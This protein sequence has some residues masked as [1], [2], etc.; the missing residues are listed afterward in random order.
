MCCE[1]LTLVE[2][3]GMCGCSQTLG[4]KKETCMQ[5]EN[6]SSLCEFKSA[7]VAVRLVLLRFCSTTATEWVI[8]IRTAIINLHQARFS[9]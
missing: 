9:S 6:E 7:V 5:A 1:G 4:S 2:G 8:R 3:K